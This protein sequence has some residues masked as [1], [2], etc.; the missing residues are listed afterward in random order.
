[1]IVSDSLLLATLVKAFFPPFFCTSLLFLLFVFVIARIHMRLGRDHSAKIV[2]LIVDAMKLTRT[3]YYVSVTVL[4]FV[5]CDLLYQ[6]LVW[7]GGR[8]RDKRWGH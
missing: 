6:V 3:P 5:G 4:F 2:L 1:M 8:G 7:W